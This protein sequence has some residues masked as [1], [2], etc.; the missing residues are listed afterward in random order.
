[1]KSYS[2]W[3]TIT[4]KVF[5]DEDEMMEVLQ[6]KYPDL[7]VWNEEEAEWVNDCT[8]E[9]ERETF[10][11]IARRKLSEHFPTDEPLKFNEAIIDLSTFQ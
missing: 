11:E 10:E 7:C 6:E 3:V 1:V 8:A 2:A 9:Q 4:G 5:V